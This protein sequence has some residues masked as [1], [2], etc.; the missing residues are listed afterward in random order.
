MDIRFF[1]THSKLVEFIWP[2]LISEEIL[3]ALIK[4][5]YYL[6]KEYGEGIKEIRKGYHTL[7]LRLQE[8]I[9]EQ[10]CQDLIEEFK[11][12]PA[13]PQDEDAAKTWTI[14]V[15]YGGEFGKD[16]DQLAKIHKLKA[17]DV[18]QMHSENV[19]TLHFYGF[20]PGFMYLGGL[21]PH[22]YTKRKERPERLIPKGTVAIGGQQTGIY[23][24][25]SPGGWYAIG[26][27]PIPLFDIQKNP[28]V[29]A[30]VGDL[31]R[32]K[33]IDLDTYRQIKEQVQQ[34]NYKLKND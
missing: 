9:S 13:E 7:S 22:L 10:D 27:C 5:Q 18:V 33:P 11:R 20:L 19:Y 25:E 34:G 17:E 6:E 3:R 26:S 30:R 12:I 8:D 32:F 21:N 1:R 24:Q 31:I 4:V 2:P 16:L 15:L 29:F 23:P 14:P 28:P